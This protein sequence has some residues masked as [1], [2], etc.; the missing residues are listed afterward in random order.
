MQFG[1]KI[2]VECLGQQDHQFVFL[3]RV[4]AVCLESHLTP[5]IQLRSAAVPMWPMGSLFSDTG[6]RRDPEIPSPSGRGVVLPAAWIALDCLCTCS[7]PFAHVTIHLSALRKQP[8]VGVLV[9]S[10]GSG[11]GL[12]PDYHTP[13]ALHGGTPSL[14]CSAG[15][16][17]P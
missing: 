15:A 12:G 3:D 1:S 7:K 10:P 16:V 2:K 8:G 13:L 17:S 5:E 4:P 11:P 9:T 14:G 6:L